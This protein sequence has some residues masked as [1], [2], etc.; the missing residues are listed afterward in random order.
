MKRTTILGVLFAVVMGTSVLLSGCT[1]NNG[2]N[3]GT[4]ND[5]DININEKESE[6]FIK[7]ATDRFSCARRFGYVQQ[8][9][10]VARPDV[11]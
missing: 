9:V 11:V 5:Y 8:G 2:G 4:M 1:S 7:F 10:G 6:N 3:S